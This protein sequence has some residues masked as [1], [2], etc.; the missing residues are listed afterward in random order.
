[1]NT[2]GIRQ[3]L[4]DLRRQKNVI[5]EAMKNLR[6]LLMQLD[7]ERHPEGFL[8]HE[9][10]IAAAPPRASYLDLAVKAIE[11]ND[12]QPMHINSIVEHIRV[13]KGN[14]DIKRQSIDTTLCRHLAMK[15]GRSRIV[16]VSPG[17]YG[18]RG[19]PRQEPAA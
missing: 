10:E 5:D 1:M 15:G 14:L 12:C 17:I 16:R 3:V 9:R 4:E 7:K 13:A 6:L 18:V 8:V 11:A 2:K 19:L